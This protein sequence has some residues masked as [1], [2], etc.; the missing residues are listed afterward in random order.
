LKTLEK[1][2]RKEI[3]KSLEKGKPILAQVGPLS[4]APARAPARPLCLTGGPRLSAPTS[5]PSLPLCLS[6]PRGP[7]LSAPSSR[8][9]PRFS[10]CPAVPTCQLVLNLPP[11]ISPPWTRPQPRVLRP[12][13]RPRAPFEPRAL[14]AHLSSLVCALCP[15]LSPSLSLCPRVQ[16]APPPPAVD[17]C[18]FRGRRR[19]RAPSSAT[20][21]SA[22]LSAARDTLRCALSLPVASSP[23]S[24]E[25]L[26]CNWSSATIAPSSPCASAVASRLQ[27]F[28][29]R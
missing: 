4:P 27:R 23:R 5:A 22:L 13:P 24:P 28:C 15:T 21:S 17:R 16:G 9:R 14:L 11:T 29:S 12:R 20:V 8:T 19:A 7:G 2:N 10:L 25:F 18:L 1:I 26:L 6:L 3:R